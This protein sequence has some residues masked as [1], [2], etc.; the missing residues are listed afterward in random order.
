MNETVEPATELAVAGAEPL[1]IIGMSCRYPGG[2]RSPEALW[3]LLADR[4]DVLSDFP[5]DRNWDLENL[6]SE[7]PASAGKT[8]LTRG[9]FLEDAAGFD[10]GFF[11]IPPREALS[12]EPQQRLLLEASW[13]ALEHAA[14]TP[15]AVRDTR[16]GV[17]VGAE[18]R[19]Y[20]PRLQDAPES[21]KGYLLTGTTTSVMSGR[22][23]YLLGL[24]GPSLT[25]DTS[26]SSS[27]VAIH[28]AAQALRQGDCSLALAGGVSV[29]S[30]PGNFVAFS[31]LRA[32]SPEG[33]CKPFSASADG[34]VWSEGVGLI[35]L[36]RL[37]DALRNGHRVLAVLRGSAINSDGTS[38]GLTAPN[39]QAQQAVIR[40]ALSNAGLTAQDVDAVE[41]HGTGTRLGDPIEAQALLATY[42]QERPGERPLWLGSVK[43]NIGH[44]QAAAGAAGVIKMVLA[45]R[46]QQLPAMLHADEPS[47]HVDWS[48]GQVRLLTEPVPWPAGE[49]ARRAGVSAFGLSGTNVHLILE[50]APATQAA[51]L[52]ADEGAPATTPVVSG[53]E[54]WVIS[55]R[56]TDGLAAQ[57]DRLH[58]W[59]AARPELEPADVAWSLTATRSVFEHRAV[60]VGTDREDLLTGMRSLAG[61]VP[62]GSVVS[63]V[64]RPAAQVAFVFP[65]Q[66]SQ[67]AAM[68][69][70]LALSSPVFAARLTECEQALAPYVDWSLTEVLAGAPGAPELE[71][72]DVVQ[73]VLWAVMV[74]LAA[75]W[76]ASGVTP[77][78]VVGHSQGE[79][80]A[81]TV[82]GMLGLEDAAKVVSLRSQSLRV[83]SGAGG[84]LS[85][86]EPAAQVE[87]RLDR[88]EGRLSVAAVNGPAAIV[89][90]GEV[91][92]LEELAREL[93]A[94]SVRHR[95]V[96][97]DY[98]SHCAQ[99]ERL[100]QEILSIL[101]GLA[102]RQ[103]RVPMV[104]AMSG[105][106]LTGTELDAA[107]WYGSLRAP[108]HFDRAVRIL[109]GMGHQVFLEIS[110]HP[111]LMGA[112]TDTL[113]EAALEA[114]PGTIAGVVCGTLRR[115]E[116]GAARLLTSLAEA[117]V[118]GAPVDWTAVLPPRRQ[119]ELPTY[120]FQ[121]ERY[122]LDG[123]ARPD[124]AELPLSAGLPATS[125]APK[126][127]TGALRH[128][129]E[130]PE[131]EQLQ[132]ILDLIQRHAAA[133]L[134]H[135]SPQTIEPAH[136]FKELGFD[137]VTGVELRNRLSSAVALQLPTTLIFDYPTPSA[138]T[139]FLRAQALGTPDETAPRPRTAAP[140]DDP[141]AIV[142]MSCRLPG[143]VRAPEELWALLAE[144]GDGVAELPTDRGWDLAELY[145]PDST[146]PG[147]FYAREGGFISGAGE[148]DAAFFGI[149]PREALAMDPQQRLLL[150]M[151]WEAFERA[152]I[153]PA[154]LRGSATGVFVGA[155]ASG[156]GA[157]AP[158]GLEG[159][160]Q[161]G[162]APSVI[163]GRVAYTFGLEGP[164]VTVDT[165]CSSSLVALHLA[166]QALRSGECSLALVG[167]VTVHAT[168][169][170]L[171]WFSRQQ[172]LAADGRCKAFSDEADGMGMAEGAGVILLERLSEA[173]RLGHEVLAVVSG[174]AVNQD[175]ASNGLTAP[176]GPAQQRV[177]R[178]ALASAGLGT[179]DVDVVEGHGTGTPLGDPIEAQALIATYGQDRPEEQP[180]W[181]GSVKSNIGHTQWAAGVAG[182]I[183]MVTAMQH[184]VVPA[185]LHADA[186]TSHVDWDTGAVRLVTETM[187]WPDAGRPRR[188]GVSSFGISGT[189]AHVIIEQAPADDA[190]QADPADG[191]AG[192]PP[193]VPWVVSGRTAAGLAAQAEKLSAFV[194]SRADAGVAG[195]GRSLVA[196]RSALEHRAVVL[197]SD[198][199]ELLAGL[200]ALA[201]GREVA[202]VVTG[203]VG[204]V[205]KVGFVFT[206]QGAQRLGMGRELYEAFPVFAG[207]FDAVC[208]GLDEHLNGSVAAVVRGEGLPDWVGAGLVDETVWA[209]AGLFAVEVALFRLLESWGI[210]PQVV[211]GHSIGE[212]AAAHVAGVWSL[213]DAC[214]VVAARGRLMQELPSGGAMVAVEAT[215]EQVAEA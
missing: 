163:S 92:A 90:S 215:E 95:M 170:W 202:G 79:I 57:A 75:V 171:V 199:E 188:A 212:L 8:Y 3:K 105:E 151:S 136:T 107:Y 46:N 115:D 54:A 50:E 152:G 173:R 209:Q 48:A 134:G 120:A 211:A 168:P 77:D 78:A 178:S 71:S 42:G 207:A 40:R 159:H 113:E 56:S 147:T 111:V 73:P 169:A 33:V 190:V 84:M 93:E 58:E 76:E 11:G 184:G 198:R 67:W 117:F 154:R 6:Y 29:M 37:S 185:T 87:E 135:P 15:A 34:T 205:G 201:E 146:R 16:T 49:R 196:M 80:A 161:S 14:L 12:M 206:G 20:G 121:H 70:E 13:E 156:Y 104:S 108:V 47:P 102:P 1:A 197:G 109:S 63:G 118:H 19:E 24:H 157:G 116:G 194:Q 126:A 153:D 41:A 99:V 181:L 45:L 150:E 35:V 208:A 60:V 27:L 52:A 164:A 65:G 187:P 103:G 114:G 74:S 2:V 189:N 112:M 139:E 4:R 31:G 69:R 9:G 214:A 21:V 191:D 7:D 25:V 98:A 192:L 83:L 144:G 149:S 172:G 204:P 200:D 94:E 61:G 64:A 55:G 110:P 133:I 82:A 193:V 106:V 81:A 162:I 131:P 137:S 182:I 132:T 125:P 179:G 10:A 89:V 165:A 123:G 86:T 101:A 62:A 180:L 66:G 122:W 155:A 28:L 143:G 176:N 167:G 88:W 138:L 127:G 100:E 145:D 26:A 119:V 17:F 166:T 148:F 141:I 203:V 195:V 210:A 30:T 97:V 51:E 140:T 158:E 160:L 186:P 32:L 59:V 177:I 38:E 68:G 44:T 96:A 43:S 91:T 129:A 175:G 18:P 124:M 142:S 174:S 213:E 5:A 183:K 53:A 39:G 85:V 130:L 128:L 36:E 23:S 22:I 72:A